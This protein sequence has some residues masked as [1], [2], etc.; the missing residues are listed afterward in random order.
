MQTSHTFTVH[1]LGTGQAMSSTGRMSFNPAGSSKVCHT[2]ETSDE[3]PQSTIVTL[4]AYLV[5]TQRRLMGF[6]IHSSSRPGADIGRRI[7]QSLF[8]HA[9]LAT[10]CGCS[11]PTIGRLN[12]L[13]G[14]F[15]A[16]TVIPISGQSPPFQSTPSMRVILDRV[17]LK[18]GHCPPFLAH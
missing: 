5:M 16:K 14:L 10:G 3:V 7:Q 17:P 18:D 9:E 1:G 11:A 15:P 8:L 4:R 13:C 2:I 12:G 6:G